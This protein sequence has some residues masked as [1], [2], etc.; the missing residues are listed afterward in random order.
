MKFIFNSFQFQIDQFQCHKFC[1]NIIHHLVPLFSHKTWMKII[2]L[3]Y[4]IL[5]TK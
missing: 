4:S 3:I 1:F 5:G 2:H